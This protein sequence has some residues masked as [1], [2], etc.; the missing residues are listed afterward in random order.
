MKS[1]RVMSIL[2]TAALSAETM[3]APLSVLASSD[4]VPQSSDVV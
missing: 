4:V 3:F 2:L 1:R